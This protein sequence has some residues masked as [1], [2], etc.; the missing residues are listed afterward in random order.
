MMWSN[1]SGEWPRRRAGF[2]GHVFRLFSGRWSRLSSQGSPPSFGFRRAWTE[3]SSVLSFMSPVST[4]TR[5][6]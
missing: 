3:A 2:E 6:G 1:C 5:L 4:K